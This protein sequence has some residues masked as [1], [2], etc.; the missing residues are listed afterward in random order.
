MYCR[1]QSNPLSGVL[2][3]VLAGII[4]GLLFYI[5]DNRSPLQSSPS[6]VQPA[7]AVK[8]SLSTARSQPDA[9]APNLTSVFIP[10][11]GIRTDVIETYLDGTSWDISS[12]GMNAGHLQGTAWLDRPGN[13]VLAGHVE[14]ADGRAGVFAN[15]GE[16]KIG[17]PIVLARGSDEWHYVITQLET[18]APDDLSV[19]YP[20]GTDQL[21]LVT[22][23]NYNFF[24]DAYLEREVVIAERI[25]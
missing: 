22:C 21:T 19:L 14:M 4:M 2:H 15:I 16:L 17:D 3:M 5:T 8:A 11:A 6:A 7:S 13:I 18:V 23:S 12:L 9:A 24:Q 10:T 25:A 20:T 1:K